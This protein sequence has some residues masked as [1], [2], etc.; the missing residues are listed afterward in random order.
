PAPGKPRLA[1]IHSL[2]LDRSIWDPVVAALASDFEILAHDARGHG[3]SEHRPGPYTTRQFA[4]DLA[5]IFDAI[6]WKSAIVAGCSM[7]GCIAQ[8]FAIAY[9]ERT[10]AL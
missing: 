7:G 6:G 9:P 5:T 8:A 2:A 4:D 3:L 1:L 10:Q